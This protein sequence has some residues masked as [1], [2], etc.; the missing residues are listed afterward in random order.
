MKIT[1]NIDNEVSNIEVFDGTDYLLISN[2]GEET[3]L[4]TTIKEEDIKSSI[5]QIT[6]EVMNACLKPLIKSAVTKGLED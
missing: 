1:I 4:Q 3:T 5:Y 2:I 6:S